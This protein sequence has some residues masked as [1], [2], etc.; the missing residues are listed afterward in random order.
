MYGTP[1]GKKKKNIYIYIYIWLCRYR[2][3]S[4]NM[5]IRNAAHFGAALPLL[6]PLSVKL[7]YYLYSNLN[8]VT[9]FLDARDYISIP[10]EGTALSNRL[11][12]RGN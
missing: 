7:N 6:N 4:L 9:L 10:D 12:L 11:S 1:G 3:L 8:N 5:Y 2:T